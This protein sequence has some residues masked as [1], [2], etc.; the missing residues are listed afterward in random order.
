M[1]IEVIIDIKTLFV[2]NIEL[3]NHTVSIYLE[4]FFVHWRNWLAEHGQVRLER[5]AD[6]S[7]PF[8]STW[9]R[10]L[11]YGWRN[12]CGPVLAT[13]RWCAVSETDC[14]QPSHV[15]RFQRIFLLLNLISTPDFINVSWQMLSILLTH[16]GCNRYLIERDTIACLDHPRNFVPVTFGFEVSRAGRRLIFFDDDLPVGVFINIP[17]RVEVVFLFPNYIIVILI[18]SL[19]DSLANISLFDSLLLGNSGKCLEVNVLLL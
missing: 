17:F 9:L 19:S 8:L 13:S 12:C 16:D 1:N 10:L 14:I 2:L 15:V 18:G 3:L 7:R 5:L 4:I 6:L 11:I